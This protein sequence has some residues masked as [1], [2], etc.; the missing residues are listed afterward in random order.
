MVLPSIIAVIPPTVC[1]ALAIY[2]GL[3]GWNDRGIKVFMVLLLAL[4]GYGV[5]QVIIQSQHD[6]DE[7]AGLFRIRTAFWGLIAPLSYHTVIALM[8][9][10]TKRRKVILAYLYTA[11]VAFMILLF[12]GYTIFKNYYLAWWGWCAEMNY[13]SWF[14]WAF[15]TYLVTGVLALIATLFLIRRQTENYRVQ[16]LAQAIL[17]NFVWGGIFTVVPYTILSW[18]K[19]PTE[20]FLSYAGNIA[21][22]LIVFAIQKYHPE[23]LSASSLLSNLS[24]FLPTE[25]LMITPDKKILW[26]NRTKISFNGFTPKDLEGAGY[27]KVFADVAMVD[28]EMNRIK[29]DADY[30][31]S[32][33]TECNTSHGTKISVRLNLSGLRNEFND[34]IAYLVV[35]DDRYDSADL[36][37]YLQTSYE[38]SNREKEVAAMLLHGYSNMQICDR[39]FISLNTV[40]THTRNIYQKTN[41]TNRTEFKDFCANLAKE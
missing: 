17:I 10:K 3:L 27:E 29:T 7:V 4:V 34:V 12:Y 25:A 8:K 11:G 28:K 16:K 33:E 22:F 32:F 36:L 35:Y 23:K 30:S 13:N 15:H 21:M 26:L 20:I 37:E 40:K 9:D 39:L 24:S 5:V 41:T 18:F 31:S 14:F 38:L 6:I 1:V 19:L 2:V